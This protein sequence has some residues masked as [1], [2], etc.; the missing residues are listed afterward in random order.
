MLTINPSC[1]IVLGVD[2]LIDSQLGRSQVEI[3][4]FRVSHSSQSSPNSS[5]G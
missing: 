4:G 3:R 1:P 5:Q 2:V